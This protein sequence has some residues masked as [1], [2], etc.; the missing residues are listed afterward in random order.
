[1]TLISRRASIFLTLCLFLNSMNRNK[2]ELKNTKNGN[3]LKLPSF[4]N[5]LEVKSSIE[6]RVRF[7][8]PIV[9]S[10]EAVSESLISQIKKIPV[11]KKCEINIITGTILIE[12]DSSQVD[13]Q[14][15]EGAVI[16]LLG[17]DKFIDEGRVS[18]VKKESD[19]FMSA[20][21]NGLYDFTGGLFDVK[22]LV[23]VL[24]IVG[25][26]YDI[27]RFGLNR[28]PGYPTLLWWSSRLFLE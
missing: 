9:K 4:K 14:T 3:T 8:A 2:E 13:A 21:N 18:T 23:A 22:S 15:I 19:S 20:V 10:N 5:A 24:F 16:K 6:G 26:I 17:I 11:I 27:K 12:Y 28:T 1:M 25:A 7:F